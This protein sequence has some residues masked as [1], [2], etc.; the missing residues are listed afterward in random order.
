SWQIRGRTAL[1]VAAWGGYKDCISLLLGQGADL[2]KTDGHNRTPFFF[3]CLGKS[4]D[5]AMMIL[6]KLLEKD[7]PLEEINKPTKRGRTPL[8]Q[9]ASRGH[10]RVAEKL[11]SLG[12]TAEMI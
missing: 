10:V 4:E 3:A 5:T 8:R 1:H 12:M 9:T 6:E 11:L 7:V 2:N